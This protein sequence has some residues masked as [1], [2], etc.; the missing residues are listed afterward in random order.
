M[1]SCKVIFHGLKILSPPALIQHIQG[2]QENMK[3]FWKFVPFCFKIHL[4]HLLVKPDQ[5][6][7]LSINV[8]FSN[9]IKSNFHSYNE[10]L[11]KTSWHKNNEIKGTGLCKQQN[12]RCLQ[13]AGLVNGLMTKHHYQAMQ[14]FK[15]NKCAN[16]EIWSK[17]NFNQN[18]L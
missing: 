16:M 13:K 11:H 18:I 5:T 7:R 6:H 12:N 14:H 2:F 4:A 9:S 8:Y 3:T 15:Q 1:S 17:I 10:F